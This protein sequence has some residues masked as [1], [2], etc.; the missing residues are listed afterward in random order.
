MALDGWCNKD[1]CPYT[2]LVLVRGLSSCVPE[3]NNLVVSH[4]HLG[5]WHRLR[6]GGP[7][8]LPLL[9]TP[10]RA[11]L[12]CIPWRNGTEDIHLLIGK[13]LMKDAPI[14]IASKT[15]D[16]KH[17]GHSL[18]D[19]ETTQGW[20]WTQVWIYDPLTSH[21]VYRYSK[22]LALI[23]TPNKLTVKVPNY[24][25]IDQGSRVSQITIG[26]ACWCL[27]P[28][29]RGSGPPVRSLGFSAAPLIISLPA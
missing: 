21:N 12:Y 8:G 13:L 26:I 2:V 10:Q 7:R 6:Q 16:V 18:K 20:Q 17:I 4:F 24:I 15:G 29:H 27:V 14:C 19:L 28:C 3:D 25:N 23:D 9:C 22:R 11:F 1:F 5:C